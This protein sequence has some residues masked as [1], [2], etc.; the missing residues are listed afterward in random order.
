MRSKLCQALEPIRNSFVVN[1]LLP[2][3]LIGL[4]AYAVAAPQG[5]APGAFLLCMVVFWASIGLGHALADL[6][7][8]YMGNPE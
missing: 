2:G 1:K 4:F 8:R 5:E 6:A 3:I 7:T